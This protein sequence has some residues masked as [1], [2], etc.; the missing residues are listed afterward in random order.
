MNVKVP[1]FD[2]VAVFQMSKSQFRHIDVL[3]LNTLDTLFPLSQTMIKN[4]YQIQFFWL[5]VKIS[6]FQG[7]FTKQF[8]SKMQALRM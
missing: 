3:V 2:Q 4:T 5:S 1:I 8:N 7:Y 6:K